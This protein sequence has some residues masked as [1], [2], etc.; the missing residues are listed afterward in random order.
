V[1]FF[2]LAF[3]VLAQ[4]GTVD[5]GNEVRP[6]CGN[7]QSNESSPGARWLAY[8]RRELARFGSKQ[9]ARA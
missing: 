6:I 7:R 9:K 4:S 1:L 3:I 5:D 2:V 8:W